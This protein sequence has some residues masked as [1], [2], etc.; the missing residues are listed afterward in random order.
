MPMPFRVSP[1]GEAPKGFCCLCLGD[2]CSAHGCL[3][4]RLA[5]GCFA[6]RCELAR[7]SFGKFVNDERG[8]LF[9]VIDVDHQAGRTDGSFRPNQIYAVGGLPRA[10]VDGAVARRIVEIGRAHV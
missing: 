9:D 5:E 4:L 6:A 2:A 10:V 3:Q 1:R 7:A 8:I